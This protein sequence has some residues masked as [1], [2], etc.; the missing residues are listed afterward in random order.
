M[1][2]LSMP[3]PVCAR[4]V[5]MIYLHEWT[6]QLLVQ[7]CTA[8]QSVDRPGKTTGSRMTHLLQNTAGTQTTTAIKW[9]QNNH[10]MSANYC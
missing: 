9:C 10:Q 6:I 4:K 2:D 1:F 3:H 7:V 5:D 8:R